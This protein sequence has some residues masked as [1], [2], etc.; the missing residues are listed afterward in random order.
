MPRPSRDQL[1]SGPGWDCDDL[2]VAVVE[3]DEALDAVRVNRVWK[4]F[5]AGVNAADWLTVVEDD[6]RPRVTARLR[7]TLRSRQPAA[8]EVRGAADGQWLELRVA[9]AGSGLLVTLL[10]RTEQKDREESL[11]A[12]AVH[13]PL[14][15]LL[16]RVALLQRTEQC[17]ARQARQPSVAAL[18]F[19][20]LDRF[21]QVNDR[22]GHAE[23]D[24]VF[25]AVGQRLTGAI[26]PSD[27]L[28]RF[29]GDE[30]VVLCE[31]LASEEEVFG[32]VDRLAAA[33]EEPISVNGGI[34]VVLGATVGVAFAYGPGD[35]AAGLI[36][37]ADR[38]M[39][40]AKEQGLRV[41]FSRTMDLHR[42]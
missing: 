30:F 40:E 4:A 39:Y 15:G 1:Q 33:I 41:G 7:R 13:D 24:R 34:A 35:D 14:T 20:D 10:D 11:A 31:S 9:A 18:L 32:V 38:A 29:G 42:H 3:T 25:S 23:G 21:K 6:E 16:N 2:P 28:A 22:Y 17:L 8:L 26:R 27:T 37:R 36:D 19:I 12:E 5:T